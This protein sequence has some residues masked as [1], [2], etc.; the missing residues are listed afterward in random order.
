MRS[1][2]DD[3]PMTTTSSLPKVVWPCVVY[4]DAPAAITFLRDALGFVPTIV[5]SHPENPALIEHAELQWPEGGGVMLGSSARDESPFSK[6][7]IGGS[8]IYV[9]TDDPHGVH[10]R[11]M[12]GGATLVREMRDEDY[13]STGFTVA[14]PEGNLWSFGTYR[15]EPLPDAYG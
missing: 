7:P 6:K 4:A 8:S 15:G 14:D 5:V 9:V 13:G 10:A 3:E 1:M 11:A 12:A 2:A